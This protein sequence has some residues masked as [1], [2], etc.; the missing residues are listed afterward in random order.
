MSLALASLV[1]LATPQDPPF[2]DVYFA[3]FNRVLT[4]PADQG[5]RRLWEPMPAVLHEWAE[6]QDANKLP[7]ADFLR[8]ICRQPIRLRVTESEDEL[9]PAALPVRLQF[10]L[11]DIPEEST[12]GLLAELDRVFDGEG[13]GAP[14]RS[15]RSSGLSERSEGPVTLVYGQLGSDA[16]LSLGEPWPTGAPQGS[17]VPPGGRLLAAGRLDPERLL[18]LYFSAFGFFGTPEIP[19]WYRAL[20]GGLEVEAWW[21]ASDRTGMGTVRLGQ[22]GRVGEELGILTGE[23]LRVEDLARVPEDAGAAVLWSASP[24]GLLSAAALLADDAIQA[25]ELVPVLAEAGE[26]AARMLGSRGGVWLADSTG[27]L[28]LTAMVLFQELAP[29]A[30]VDELFDFIATSVHEPQRVKRGELG[31][32]PTLSIQFPGLPIPIEPTFAARDGALWFAPLPGSLLAAFD[33][34]AS[35][36]DRLELE[37]GALAFAYLDTAALAPRGAALLSLGTTA[38][39]NALRGRVDLPAGPFVTFEPGEDARPM[40]ATLHRRGDDLIASATFDPAVTRNLSGILGLADHQLSLIAAIGFLR[41]WRS[42]GSLFGWGGTD[43]SAEEVVIEATIAESSDDRNAPTAAKQRKAKADLLTLSTAIQAYRMR[44]GGIAPKSLEILVTPDE[45]GHRYID[46][47]EVPTDP[48]SG[49]PLKYK[50][51]NGQVTVYGVGVN[52]V[53]DQGINQNIS[54]GPEEGD[55]WGFPLP[56]EPEDEY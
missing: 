21:S 34:Q 29:G 30:D 31:G 36:A 9:S 44:N 32:A 28:D 3:G 10:E 37:D 48:Y 56:P 13:S 49:D 12:A 52:L 43:Y 11:H 42:G 26:L 39:A 18:E 16:L 33:A 55:D 35:L 54:G 17:V 27:G 22:M 53:D 47:T 15:T 5:L 6:S 14:P 25:P 51:E 1:L 40:V 8:Q 2:L 19:D 7:L 50:V 41:S 46:R 45:N 23:P 38:A 24:E 20:L 4:H